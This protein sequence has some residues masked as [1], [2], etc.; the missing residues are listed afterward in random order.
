MRLLFL[1]FSFASLSAQQQPW[2][3]LLQTPKPALKQLPDKEGATIWTTTHFIIVCE[4]TIPRPRLEEF[5]QTMESVPRLLK[6][7]PLPLWVPPKTEKSVTR[8]C[9][10][11]TSLVARGAPVGAAG[12]YH[13]RSGEILIRGDLLLKPPQARATRL[14]PLPNEDLL[15][16]ELTHLALHQYGASIPTWLQEGLPEYF[17]AC[18]VRKGSYDFTQ[19]HR[20][21]KQHIEK[22]YPYERFPIVAVPTPTRLSKRS[23]SQWLETIRVS[24]VEDAYRQYAG[25]LL[26]T[27]YYLEGGAKRRNELKDYLTEALSI[28]HLRKMPPLLE[29]PDDVQKRLATFW[30]SKGLHLKFSVDL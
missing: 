17:A 11:E 4:I 30:K 25:S 20:L 29:E 21:I 5:A 9:A 23:P 10:N 3:E 26:L 28:A 6:R 24:A 19:S 12:C 16:H 14:Q 15:I 1:L 7:L 13:P 18:H 8:I 22:F 2:P 27:H